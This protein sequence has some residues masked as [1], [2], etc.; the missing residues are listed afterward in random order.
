MNLITLFAAVVLIESG[1]DI[2]ALGDNGRAYGPAQIHQA[3]LTDYNRWTGA[4][5][6]L[7]DCTDLT[8][9][10]KV[11]F[12]YVKHYCT[13]SR[14]GRPVTVR[15]AARIW[16]GGPDGWRQSETLLYWQKI[17]K[18]IRGKQCPK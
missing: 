17:N 15:D 16:N 18:A 10:R 9:S 1:G 7:A 13:K 8:L 2:Q 11:F 12:A 3:A 14:L 4:H 6:T 5:Y